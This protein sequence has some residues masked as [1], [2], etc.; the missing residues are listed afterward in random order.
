MVLDKI[1]ESDVDGIDE[2]EVI[3]VDDGSKPRSEPVV[4]EKKVSSPFTLHYFWQE[5]AGPAAARNY[6]F[7][8]ARGEI[9]ICVDD[10]ILLE[11]DAVKWHVNAHKM[12]PG[13]VIFGQCLIRQPADSG[14]VIK[15][16]NGLQDGEQ[17][18]G[19]L[20]PQ[21]V[22]AS[23]QI[24]FE[25]KQFNGSGPYRDDLR[26]PAAEEYELSYRLQK[27]GIPIYL[28]ARA[29]G[30]HLVN[31][32]V[33]DKAIQEFKYG[34]AVGECI[35]KVPELQNF[36]PYLKIYQ[37]NCK[38]DFSKDSPLLILKKITKSVFS[39]AIIRKFLVM[40]GQAAAGSRLPESLKSK[41]LRWI[42]GI[43]LQAGV[44]EGM[45][46]FQN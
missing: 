25:K 29:K 26:T 32:T 38:I 41:L 28:E 23:G 13:S 31:A 5:N 2:L 11:P 24:S 14:Y 36:E 7:R 42:F 39:P 46:K 21:P 33:S 8:E 27:Q 16:L 22:I 40:V 10:D 9:V 18:I 12:R 34:N 3:V 4:A 6:G 1:L 43:N 45:R 17:P 15:Y 44:R 30:E 20:L 37:T 35:Y 19:E